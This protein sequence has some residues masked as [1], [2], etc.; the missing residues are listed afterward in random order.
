MK[1]RRKLVTRVKYNH[2]FRL[3]DRTLHRPFTGFV[4]LTTTKF[5]HRSAV[6]L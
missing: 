6:D 3:V 2:F 4:F 1:K 5:M